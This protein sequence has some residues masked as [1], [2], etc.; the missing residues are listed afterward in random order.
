MKL[1]FKVAKEFDVSMS[2]VVEALQKKGIEIEN[3]PTAKVPYE[4]YAELRIEFQGSM[5]KN[6][7]EKADH[8]QK[9]ATPEVSK[10]KPKLADVPVV[11]P[12]EIMRIEAPQSQGLKILRKIDTTKFKEPTRKKE[13][14]KIEPPIQVTYHMADIAQKRKKAEPKKTKW[15]EFEEEFE[16]LVIEM[17]SKGFTKSKQ[18]SRYIV[19]N[20]LGNKYQNISGV[21]KMSNGMDTWDFHGGFPPNIYAELCRRLNLT[22][23]VSGAIPGEFVSFKDLNNKY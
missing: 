16:S 3:K 1:L 10:K 9:V 4:M 11:I 14:P 6:E 7:Q 17:A 8:L 22:N 23:E 19:E 12:E 18:V 2:T 5:I 20:R 21:L 13:E 15:E